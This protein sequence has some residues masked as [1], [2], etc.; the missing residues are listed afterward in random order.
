MPPIL[1]KLLNVTSP[2]ATDFEAQKETESVKIGPGP[3]YQIMG[4]HPLLE[5]K[6]I[7]N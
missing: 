5:R 3:T 2:P 6:N 7:T 4:Q 1:P